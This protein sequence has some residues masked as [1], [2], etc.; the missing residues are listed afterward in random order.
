MASPR[1]LPDALW[2]PNLLR[3]RELAELRVVQCYTD[4]TTTRARIA[5]RGTSRS[6]HADATVVAS[7]EGSDQ[8]LEQFHRLA[9]D[10][11]S[12]DVDT[13]TEYDPAIG[14]ILTFINST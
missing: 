5:A 12:L 8:Y 7:L 1:R 9:V 13:T 3:L 11:P 4:A 6:A 10:A 14:E 2:T